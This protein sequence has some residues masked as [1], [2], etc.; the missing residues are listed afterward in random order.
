MSQIPTK[1]YA[2][3]KSCDTKIKHTNIDEAMIQGKFAMSKCNKQ[4]FTYLCRICNKWHLTS[5]ETKYKII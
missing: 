4:L 1:G 2:K 3:F 5:K